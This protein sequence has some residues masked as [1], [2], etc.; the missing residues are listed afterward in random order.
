[1]ESARR[2]RLVRLHR[3]IRRLRLERRLMIAAVTAGNV[4]AVVRT[5]ASLH[6]HSHAP[7][8][9][10]WTFLLLGTLICLGIGHRIEHRVV[11]LEAEIAR[12]ASQR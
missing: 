3:Q 4:G 12:L 11:E 9:V 8:V 6:E 1:M 7:H 10:A 5:F 2:R